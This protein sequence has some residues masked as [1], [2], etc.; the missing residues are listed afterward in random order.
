MLRVVVDVNVV[1]SA[2][3]TPGGTPH[4]LLERWL[5]GA[6]EVVAS[7]MLMGELDRVLARPEIR[8]RSVPEVFDRFAGALRADALL[9]DDPQVIPG[10]VER[11]A[12]DDYLVALARAAG[13]HAI[14]TGDRHL[15]DVD[16]L[17][18]PALTPRAFL[19]WLDG[20]GQR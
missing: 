2:L 3:L 9:V 19:A 17:R 8:E 16:G 15:L 14:V 10:V 4:R 6:F 1:V 18:P 11:D 5:E 12:K 20:L 7:P 13:A